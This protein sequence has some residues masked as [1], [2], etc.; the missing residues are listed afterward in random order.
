[1]SAKLEG[2]VV[3]GERVLVGEGLI[4]HRLQTVARDSSD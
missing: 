2:E 1:M 3:V 4:G